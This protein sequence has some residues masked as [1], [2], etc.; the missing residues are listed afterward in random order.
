MKEVFKAFGFVI[1]GIF[2]LIKYGGQ[3]FD[4]F[5]TYGRSDQKL[6]IRRG[7]EYYKSK[8]LVIN[9]ENYIVS[10][11]TIKEVFIKN[12]T[13]KHLNSLYPETNFSIKSICLLSEEN[14]NE[15]YGIT[16]YIDNPT[17]TDTIFYQYEIT[18]AKIDPETILSKK[19]ENTLQMEIID[20]SGLTLKTD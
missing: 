14:I 16:A 15:K 8:N 4:L 10:S 11:N 17:A 13:R 12:E 20:Y 19:S 1:L 6:N 9:A 18:I 3:Y 2:A 5:D 7:S